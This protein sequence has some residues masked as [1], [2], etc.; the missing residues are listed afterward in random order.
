[1][2]AKDDLLSS[3]KNAIVDLTP[4]TRLDCANFCPEVI[5]KR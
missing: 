5:L 3:A 1:M 2:Y 4:V